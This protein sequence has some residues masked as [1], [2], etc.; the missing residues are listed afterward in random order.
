MSQKTVTVCDKCGAQIQS[1]SGFRLGEAIASLPAGP[2]A[3][4]GGV[5]E[6][7]DW[8]LLCFCGVLGLDTSVF[9]KYTGISSF[10]P[11]LQKMCQP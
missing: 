6:P 7:G 3:Q 8:C 1:T 10:P 11:S 2:L 4:V 9:A 5:A